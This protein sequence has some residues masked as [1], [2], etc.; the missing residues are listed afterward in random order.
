MK[1]KKM[2][3]RKKPDNEIKRELLQKLELYLKKV[4]ELRSN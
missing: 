1:Q 2:Y 4:N 3:K